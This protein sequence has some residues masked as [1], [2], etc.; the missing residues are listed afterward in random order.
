MQKEKRELKANGSAVKAVPFPNGSSK[1]SVK[2][3]MNAVYDASKAARTA[4][5]EAAYQK[6]ADDLKA[7]QN[8]SKE[9]FDSQKRQME[10][11]AQQANVSFNQ[12]ANAYGLNSGAV[13]QAALIRNNQA[14]TNLGDM[15]RAYGRSNDTIEQQKQAL[16]R[17]KQYAM[18]Q[19]I[20]DNEY[21]R[22]K[23]LYAESVRIDNLNQQQAQ[24][25]RQQN[26]E[27][28]QTQYKMGVARKKAEA[29]AAEQ[30]AKAARAA[31]ADYSGKVITDKDAIAEYNEYLEWA[32]AASGLKMPRAYVGM[33]EEMLNKM[34]D[35]AANIKMPEQ[36]IIQ[37]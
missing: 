35:E 36:P 37:E 9:A 21:E 24:M 13:G 2:D 20:A 25:E 5:L 12:L 16:E 22:N 14:Q 17:D 1:N 15:A 33:T 19:V 27:N 32:E 30:A 31:Q 10:G 34:L 4:Q 23:A 26:F 7:A 6:S 8:V 29:K 28:F 11:R 18:Q 3:Y